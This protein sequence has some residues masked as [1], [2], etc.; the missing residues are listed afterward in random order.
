MKIFACLS[1]LLVQAILASA[2]HAQTVTTSDLKD[3]TRVQVS[4]YN[5]NLGLI[6]ETRRI[7]LPAGEGELRFM[8]VAPRI[9]PATV[10]TSSL[11]GA[12]GFSVLEQSYEYDL[13]DPKKLLDM[14][15]GRK[16]KIVT[17]NEAHDRKEEVEATL[18]S[19]NQDQILEIGGEIYL[20]HPGYR[21]LPS[22]PG[23]LV[24]RPT[25][26]WKYSNRS[27]EPVELE[28]S[29][30]TTGMNWS[31]DY[32]LLIDSAETSSQLSAWVNIDNRSGAAYR[33]AELKLI[34][35]DVHRVQD[36]RN[37]AV[38]QASAMRTAEAPPAPQL[39]ESPLFEYHVYDLQR[40]TTL[41]DHEA[42][43]IHLLDARGVGVR[44]EFVVHGARMAGVRRS[45][46]EPVAQPV[47]VSM[48]F[49]N[50]KENHLGVV[51]PAGVVRLYRTDGEG[52]RVFIG[53]D[54]IDHAPVN[55]DVRLQVGETREITATR[56]QI[57]FRQISS[58]LHETEWE[59]TLKNHKET[60]VSVGVIEPLSG[61]W[62]MV[63]NSHPFKKADAFT[64]RFDVKVPPKGDV[65]LTYR[66]QVGL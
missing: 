33:D 43:Q 24:A 47:T 21:V 9:L 31:A 42:K 58:R 36:G 23:D 44:K 41:E 26:A 29:Y 49:K 16:I 8:D 39:Q 57:D 18:L 59:I 35:G 60:E 46:E 66:V 28:V 19:N 11:K 55:E 12:D 53:E 54:R 48:V 52:D 1:C 22:L 2:L 3:R 61:N 38:L 4:V 25:L 50:T 5:S 51:L 6:K 32:I 7:A 17:W 56:V 65:K 34:A 45:V 37:A 13:L 64:I 20:G 10:H 40:K 14:Y 30:L 62:K 15:V 63:S 27:R